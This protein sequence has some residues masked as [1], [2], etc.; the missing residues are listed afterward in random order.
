MGKGQGGVI[1]STPA[2][3]QEFSLVEHHRVSA[4]I[5]PRPQSR[6]RV[7]KSGLVISSTKHVA[8]MKRDLITAVRASRPPAPPPADVPLHLAVECTMPILSPRRH[9]Q[10][11]TGRPDADNLVKAIKD[12][13]VDAQLIADDSQIAVVEVAKLY[14]PPP[15]AIA[16][17][18][19]RIESPPANDN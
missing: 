10:L 13:I 5:R 18:L 15:G 19:S 17:T 3:G 8:R 6:P 1:Y 2:T 16:L 7:L 4:P 9:G 12:A 14:G 11:H